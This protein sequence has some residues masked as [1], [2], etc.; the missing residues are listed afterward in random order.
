MCDG[1]NLGAAAHH[2]TKK[3]VKYVGNGHMY[4]SYQV[5]VV[6][7]KFGQAQQQGVHILLEA[8]LPVN[9]TIRLGTIV[10]TKVPA[11]KQTGTIAPTFLNRL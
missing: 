7:R 3:V 8:Q 10:P 4:P 6:T 11:S 5:E 9:S 2:L 1:V